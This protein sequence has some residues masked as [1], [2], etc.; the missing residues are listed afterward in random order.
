MQSIKHLKI[1]FKNYFRTNVRSGSLSTSHS[2]HPGG[3]PLSQST[4]GSSFCLLPS[5][6]P[7]RCTILILSCAQNSS[8]GPWRPLA[9]WQLRAAHGDLTLLCFKLAVL[10]FLLSSWHRAFCKSPERIA[11]EKQSTCIGFPFKPPPFR[12]VQTEEWKQGHWH[13]T[14]WLPSPSFWLFLSCPRKGLHNSPDFS[15]LYYLFCGQSFSL[16]L[17]WNIQTFPICHESLAFENQK[18]LF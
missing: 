16:W 11:N 17:I 9:Y 12:D 1:S 4:F 7:G 10:P 6:Y 18:Y 5:W 8:L 14:P 3:H 13:L 2:P 15:L